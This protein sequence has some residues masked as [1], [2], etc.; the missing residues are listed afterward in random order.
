MADLFQWRFVWEYLPKILRALPT[1]LLIVL[2][3]TAAG[4]VLG[5]II[6][7]IRI[8]RVPVLRQIAVVYVSFIRST[9]VF[10]QMFII[11]YGLP[12]LFMLVGINIIRWNVLFFVFVT[13]GINYSAS[14]SEIIRSS[15][16]SVGESQ[17]DAAYAAGMTKLQTYFRIILPQCVVIAVPSFGTSMVMLLQDSALAYMLGVI[18]VIGQVKTLAVSTAHSL[19]GY[20]VAMILFIILSIILEKVFGFLEKITRTQNKVTS[21]V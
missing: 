16:L 19:E 21:A 8:E 10:V 1:T 18:D 3:G 5:L 9:P 20:F 15:V 14:M 2:V 12:M 4:L 6:A 7:M 11:F 17:W 13:Y